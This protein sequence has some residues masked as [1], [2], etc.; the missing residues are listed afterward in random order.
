MSST[1]QALPADAG[2]SIGHIV[3][4]QPEETFLAIEADPQRFPVRNPRFVEDSLLWERQDGATERLSLSG[5][6]HCAAVRAGLEGPDGLMVLSYASLAG[7]LNTVEPLDVVFL[8]AGEREASAH[9]MRS[10]AAR[11]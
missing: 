7:D 11:G 4:A 5:S 8:S 3:V 10:E 6:R 9:R 2:I 1:E